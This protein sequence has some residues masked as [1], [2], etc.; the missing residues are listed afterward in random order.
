M[1]AQQI[2]ESKLRKERAREKKRSRFEGDMCFDAKPEG[3][4]RTRTKKSFFGQDSF[5]PLRYTR[6]RVGCLPKFLSPSVEGF[7]TVSS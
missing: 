7:T 3:Q 4:D 2:E 1:F 6:R 5:N